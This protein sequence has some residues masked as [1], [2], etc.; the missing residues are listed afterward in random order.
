MTKEWLVKPIMQLQSSQAVEQNSSLRAVYFNSSRPTE[1]QHNN[2][3]RGFDLG[4][5]FRGNINGKLKLN[6]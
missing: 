3:E 6:Q 4:I 5:K 1:I 2:L